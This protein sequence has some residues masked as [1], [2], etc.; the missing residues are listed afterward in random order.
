MLNHCILKGQRVGVVVDI[1]NMYYSAK[2][3][4]SAKLNYKKLLSWVVGGRTLVRAIA[5]IVQTEEIDQ[6]SFIHVLNGI[7]FEVK[8]KSLRVRMDGTAKGDWDMEIALDAIALSKRLDVICLVSGDGDFSS[9]VQMLIADGVRVEVFSFPQTTSNEL[10]A[11]ATQY[12]EIE[13]E[14][15]ILNKSRHHDT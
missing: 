9:L 5:Y 3:L 4:Y 12:Y 10:R 1:Q 6:S 14:C 11:A 15:L 2:H 13:K 8:S 7:G